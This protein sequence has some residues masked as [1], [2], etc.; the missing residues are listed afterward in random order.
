MASPAAISEISLDDVTTKG[1]TCASYSVDVPCFFYTLL[2]AGCLMQ[3]FVVPGVTV[4]EFV[5]YALAQGHHVM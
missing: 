2:M 5:A 4:T 3:Y 1:L